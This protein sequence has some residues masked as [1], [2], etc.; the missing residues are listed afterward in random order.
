M[1]GVVAVFSTPA[2]DGPDATE[3]LRALAALRAVDVTVVLVGAGPAAGRLDDGD[4]L[5]A[6]GERFLAALR[7]DGVPVLG[8]E[9]LADAVAGADAIVRVADPS[10][11]GVP[12]VFV[13]PRG[14]RPAA[15]DVAALLD[16]GQVVV[17]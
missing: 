3:A 16:A 17:A 13:W 9:A 6:D 15:S 14:A 11:G 1:S 2:L 4:A 5:S 7:E 12:A 10:R 8:P